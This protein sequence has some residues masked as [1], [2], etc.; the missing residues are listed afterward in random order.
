MNAITLRSDKELASP[1]M[2]T[3]EDRREVNS[4]KE[5]EKEHPMETPSEKFHTKKPKEVP[6]GAWPSTPHLRVL[7]Y[8]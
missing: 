2:P 4:G 3:R 6:A 5:V 7:R 8:L 1:Q